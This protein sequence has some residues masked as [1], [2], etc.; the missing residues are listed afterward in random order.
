[1]Y[2]KFR[3][4]PSSV[5]PSW[6][7]FLADYSPEPLNESSNGQPS[8]TTVTAP[9]PAPAPP[10]T[11]SPQPTATPAAQPAQ[12]APVQ[13]PPV[14][15]PPAQA[16]PVQKPPVQP[17]PA[18]AAPEKSQPAP[19]SSE[20]VRVLRGAA[21]AVVKNME[22]S[23][24][25]PTATS[26]RAIP[27]K[28]M[29]DNRIVINNHLKRTRGGKISFTHL[30]GYA[31]VQ[32]V[33]KFP[34]MNRHYAEIDGKPTAVTPEHVNLG[35]AIDLQGKDGNRQLV[36]AGIKKAETLRFSQFVAAYEDIVRRARDGK[37]TAED[38]AGVTISLTNPGTI[39]TVHS[40]PRLMRGQGAIIGVGAMEYP[41][42]FQGASE[43]RIAELG[44]GKLVTLTSTYDHRIIQGAE[45]GDFLRTVHELLLD[46]DFFDEIFRELGIPYEP[47]RWRTDNPDPIE[48]KNARVMELIAAYRNRGHLMADIDPLRLDKDRFRSHPDL[49]VLTHGLTLW[50]LDREFK[51]NG[52]AGA[53]RKKLRDVL[54]VLRDAYCRHIGVEYTHILEPEQQKWLQERIEGE[55]E[56]PTV[57]QQKYILS[58]LNAAEAFETF[59]QT[60][61]VGQKR[62]SLEG[63]ETVIPMM[64]AVIDQCAEHGLDEVVIAMP[65][66]GRL[67]VLANIVGKPY[68]QIFSEFEGNLNPSQAHGSGDV[69]YHLGASGTYI[70]MF[71]DNDIQVSLV[72]NPSHLE[73][74]DPVVE[75]LVRAKQDMLDKEGDDRFSV[76]P[77]VLHGD[78][79]FAGQGVVAETLNM[80]LLRGYRTGGTIHIIVNNQIGFTTSPDDAKSSEYCT[81][82]AKMVGAPIF[83]VNGDDPEAATWVARLA[84]DFRQKFHKDVVIDMICYRRRGHNEGDDPS[85]TQPKMYD[86]IDVKRG[87]RKSYTEALIGRGDISLKEAEDA[88]RDYQGQLERVFNEVRELEKHPVEPS[89]SVEADQMIPRG[90]PTGIDKSLLA[91][92]GDAHMALPEG[93][94]VHPRVKP[95][96]EKRREMAYEGKIDWAFAELLALGSLVAEGKTVRLSGQDSRRGTFSQRHAVIIDRKTG[97]EF[98]PLQLLT[99]DPDGNPTGGKFYVYDSPLSEFAAV[100]FEY[101]YSVGNPNALVLWEAQ[102]GDFVNG[103]QSIIDEFISS[104][105]A[106][107]GQLSDVVLLLPHGHEGQGPDHTSGRIERF[108]QLWAEGSMTIAMPSTPAN[109]FHLLRR[110]ALDG[111]R[112]PLIVFTPKSMLRNKAAVSDI[113]D[114]TE[115]KFRSVLE[116]PVYTDGDGD[117]NK[118]RR[119]LLC[120]GKLYYELAARKAK[121]GRD[122]VAIVRIEQLAPLPRR[123]IAETLDRYPNVEEKFWVQE[124]PANQ[125]AWPTFGLTL[126][127]VLPDYFTGLRRISRRAMSAPSSGSSKVHAVEQQE[128]I[129]EAFA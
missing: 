94:N 103:A 32:A 110:H 72:A 34:N 31:V 54:A 99:R 36:V 51:V 16:A 35:L 15:K 47:V 127:E 9:E 97:E 86:A 10:P 44:V 107:W 21:A 50:D 117:R 2:R 112:R 6:H 104:G 75:G 108:L 122:D 129:D 84:V 89:E 71:G 7:E 48:D 93:F 3:E 53:E 115:S 42:E 1:M 28:L 85:M 62:F 70:Q 83:H 80:A 90:L 98:T 39:G 45:S 95:V 125:G 88:L 23:L 12:A 57:A 49:D 111:I 76:V 126:P 63:A 37:L 24:E 67:N 41:A 102:F 121:D 25:V 52:F 73:A 113:R 109:Y 65:H 105:E 26:V 74:V 38:F 8:N 92:I 119:L 81:D 18:Q 79:A 114:F 106:K 46:D 91:R 13:K 33:K 118:V 64:D 56:K 100:G 123:R 78:A 27:A 68:S 5:D 20:D 77:L 87:V 61:Y 128:I 58:K 30:I 14:Q 59:L 116:E 40:V 69:K 120:S 11:P 17:T 66:R 101:G 82:V 4:D 19:G 43:E 29:I 55:H 60:K 22:A 96:L 124:E